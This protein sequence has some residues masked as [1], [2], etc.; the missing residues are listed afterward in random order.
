MGMDLGLSIDPTA[1]VYLVEDK[2]GTYWVTSSEQGGESGADAWKSHIETA[3]M[4]GAD[5]VYMDSTGIGGPTAKDMRVAYPGRFKGVHFSPDTKAQM[6]GI[7]SHLIETRR[8]KFCPGTEK[9]QRQLPTVEK[10]MTPSGK[11]TYVSTRRF[12]EGH[13]DQAWALLVACMSIKG[14]LP[15]GLGASTTGTVETPY[16]IQENPKTQA[17]KKRRFRV[18]VKSQGTR[19]L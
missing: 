11:I 3:L 15:Q 2:E 8:I 17:K 1:R 12:K 16:D 4:L 13:S 9:L 14:K 7:L 5:Q 10:G 6:V 18:R 19:G